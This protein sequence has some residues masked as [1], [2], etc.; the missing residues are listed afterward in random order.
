MK[1]T[2][3]CPGQGSWNCPVLPSFLGDRADDNHDVGDSVYP[4][5]RINGGSL[6]Q[7]LMDTIFLNHNL[8]NLYISDIFS[9]DT[10]FLQ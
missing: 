9:R 10:N 7:F 8:R 2:H 1:P 5:P 6:L 3:H 4:G